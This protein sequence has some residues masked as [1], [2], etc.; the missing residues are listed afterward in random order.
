VI[1]IR[2]R[3]PFIGGRKEAPAVDGRSIV[4]AKL[5]SEEELRKSRIAFLAADTQRVPDDKLLEELEALYPTK[6]SEFLE[7]MRGVVIALREEKRS[8]H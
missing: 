1:S 5:T 8:T 4:V 2:I 7:A 6:P 3:V